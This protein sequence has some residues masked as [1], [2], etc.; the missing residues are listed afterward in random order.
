MPA[1]SAQKIALLLLNGALCALLVL[2][3]GCHKEARSSVASNTKAFESASVD[4]KSNWNNVITAAAANDYFTAITTCRKLQGIPELTDD[5]RGAVA[6]TMGG[7]NDKLMDAVQK[8]DADATAAL[9]KIRAN[10]R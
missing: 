10:W 3:G 6:Q 5:Q 2:S 9:Q 4:I 8:G 1:K 7:L